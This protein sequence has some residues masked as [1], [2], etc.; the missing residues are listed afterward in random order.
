LLSAGPDRWAE[1]QGVGAVRAHALATALLNGTE[2]PP[3]TP[4]SERRRSR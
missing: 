4:R 2:R 1:V 3:E